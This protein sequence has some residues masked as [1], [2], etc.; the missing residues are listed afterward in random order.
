TLARRQGSQTDNEHALLQGTAMI[1]I[2]ILAWSGLTI[3]IF[4]QAGLIFFFLICAMSLA[5]ATNNQARLT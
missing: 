2:W 3:T 5:M 1:T 4:H